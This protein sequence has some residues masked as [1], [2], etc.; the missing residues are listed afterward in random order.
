MDLKQIFTPDHTQAAWEL[1][2][3]CLQLLNIKAIRKSKSIAGVHWLPTAFFAAW[4]IYNLWFYYALGLPVSWW[5]G[6][7]ITLVNLT[8]LGHLWYY[9]RA[10]GNSK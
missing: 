9:A 6:I 8:W 5:A 2:S 10:R 3:A 7:A 4:G 1:G